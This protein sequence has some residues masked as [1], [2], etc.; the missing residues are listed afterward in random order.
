MTEQ[1]QA[2]GMLR[3]AVNTWRDWPSTSKNDAMTPMTAR[4]FITVTVPA[5]VILAGLW[6]TTKA[7][8]VAEVPQQEE[9]R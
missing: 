5:L 4:E 9:A 1:E 3:V 2:E 8:P 6:S 7:Y